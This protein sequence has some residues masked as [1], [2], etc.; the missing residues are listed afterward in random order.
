MSDLRAALEAALGPLHVVEREVRPVGGCRLFV[1]L[2]LPSGPES[3]VKVLPGPLS[4][5]VD[6]RMFEREILLLADR[7]TD[8]HVVAPRAAGRAGSHVYHVRPFVEGTTLRAELAR[9]GALPLHRAVEVLRGVLTGLAHAHAAHVAHGDVKPE[10]VLVENGG[11]G[12]R[13]AAVV[14]TGVVGAVARALGAAEPDAATTAL[15]APQYLAPERREGAPPD[16]RDDMFA[17]GVLAYEML[18]GRP[19]GPHAE[20][21][22]ETRAVP[23][24]F[25][26]FVRRC[27]ATDPGARWPDAGA[28]LPS[29]SRAKWGPG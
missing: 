10:N 21:L 6:S 24:W 8:T 17:V 16:P 14:D 11:K 28:A 5:A 27:L 20:A 9:E 15:C 25:G 4:L 1:V 2:E 29:V 3:L 12:G 18:T 13:T 23:E 19:P 7:L 22:G 26:E